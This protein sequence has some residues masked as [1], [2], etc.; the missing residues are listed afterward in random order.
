MDELQ[1]AQRLLNSP[2]EGDHRKAIKLLAK[3]GDRRALALLRHAYDNAQSAEIKQLA[4]KGGAYLKENLRAEVLTPANDPITFDLPEDNYDLD[5]PDTPAI[6]PNIT[7]EWMTSAVKGE[8]KAQTKA[9]K[10]RRKSREPAESERFLATLVFISALVITFSGFLPWVS[11][12]N[13]PMPSGQT[14]GQDIADANLPDYPRPSLS[15][16][17]FGSVVFGRASVWRGLPLELSESGV[18]VRPDLLV[19]GGGGG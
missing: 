6:Q 13:Y 12:A 3:S 18:N 2:I 16:L 15:L 14:L 5:E 8:S 10:Q 17:D 4:L 11:V 7:A 19:E 9:R 1:R